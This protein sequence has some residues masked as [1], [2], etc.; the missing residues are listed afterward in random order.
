MVI[1]LFLLIMFAPLGINITQVILQLFLL[2][3]AV[4]VQVERMPSVV[5]AQRL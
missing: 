3:H 2:E 1:H 4:V 5:A